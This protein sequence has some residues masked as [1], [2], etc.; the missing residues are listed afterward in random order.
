[1]LAALD[2]GGYDGWLELEIVSDDGTVRDDFED[3]LWKRD[4]LELVSDGRAQSLA[5]LPR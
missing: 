1:M 4:P 5:L 3:S 2:R